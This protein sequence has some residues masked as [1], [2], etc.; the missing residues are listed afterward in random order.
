M[1]IADAHTA[2]AIQENKN[3]SIN[4]IFLK[5]A[6]KREIKNIK[7]ISMYLAE[8]GTAKLKINGWNKYTEPKIKIP[9]E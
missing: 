1:K 9:N 3:S 8:L 2:K 7:N 4:S 6:I 5:R